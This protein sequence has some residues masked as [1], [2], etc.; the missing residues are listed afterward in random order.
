[1]KIS[2]VT[3]I[4][5][6]GTMGKLVAGLVAAFG[7][8]I[9]YMV[10]RDKK[11]AEVAVRGAA[12][13]VKAYSVRSR[14]I[15]R[16][17]DELEDCLK[18]SDW[19]FESVAENYELKQNINEKINQYAKQ[20]AIVSTGTSGL[21]VEK[22]GNSLAEPL[23]RHY[24]GT[25]FFNPP[26]NLTLCEIIP[27]SYTDRTFLNDF[28]AYLRDVLY[29]SVVEIKDYPGFLGNRIGFQFM[30]ASLQCAEKYKEKGGI[31]YIDALLGQFTGRSMSPLATADFVGLD[32]HK[33]IVDNI[34][35][36]T[37]DYARGTFELPKFVNELVENGKLGRKTGEG[38]YK[39][40]KSNDGKKEIWVYDVLTKKYRMNNHYQFI[41][42]NQMIEA[43][44]LG[45][46][47][48]AFKLLIADSSQEADIIL[49][50]LLAYVVY[51]LK[52]SKEVAQSTRDAD[53]VMAMGF[54]WV[55]PLGIVEVLG[56]SQQTKALCV[57]RLQ[58][59]ILTQ[60]NLEE[61]F[62]DLPTSLYDYRRYFRAKQ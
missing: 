29:R 56:G 37:H 55:P 30:N 18:V 14:L 52:A 28:E 51:A 53:T 39:R 3:V 1:M 22:L 31:D 50:H 47:Q 25:H 12:E 43:F 5:A 32:I 33:A 6:N 46:Y 24:V 49:T 48:E 16:D 26:Y 57:E 59:N 61:I 10:A 7:N 38:L 45:N 23:K 60:V 2:I 21:S 15:A 9:V 58:S 13:S 27:T 34:F 4:G 11:Q 36:Y 62:E 8:A 20:D 40:I 35:N 19:I 17:Y 44:R 41:F 54:N 42:I